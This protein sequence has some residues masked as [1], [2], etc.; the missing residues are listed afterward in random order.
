M[1]SL[2]A[3]NDRI[4]NTLEGAMHKIIYSDFILLIKITYKRYIFRL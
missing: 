4:A 1:R 2:S 3:E